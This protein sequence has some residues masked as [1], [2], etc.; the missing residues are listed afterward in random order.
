MYCWGVTEMRVA[1]DELIRV[2]Q[3]STKSHSPLKLTKDIQ[4]LYVAQEE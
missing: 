1:I 4:G 3:I 2:E